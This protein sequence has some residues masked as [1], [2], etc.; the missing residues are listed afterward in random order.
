MPVITS[1]RGGVDEG[2]VHGKTGFARDEKDVAGLVAALC[3]L[4][5]EEQLLTSMG[6]AARQHS[7]ETMDMQKCIARL[8][9][10]HHVGAYNQD[11]LVRVGD[12]LGYRPCL[13]LS[14]LNVS[15]SQAIPC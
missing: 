6:D 7:I 14:F 10:P 13:A 12:F 2:I 15:M 11:V 5:D 1:A 8:H 9:P 4:L 3:S